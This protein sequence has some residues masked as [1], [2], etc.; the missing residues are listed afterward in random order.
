[1]LPNVTLNSSLTGVLEITGQTIYGKD[2][3]ADKIPFW[4]NSE[5]RLGYL[6]AGSGLYITGDVINAAVGS[7]SSDSIER[8]ITQS[9]HGFVVGDLIYHNGT[10]YAKSRA[11]V[12]ATAEVLGMVAAV[13]GV[14][15]FTLQMDGYITG[16]SGLTAG[17]VYY[18]STA[19]AGAMQSTAP[20]TL[21]HVDKPVFM[22][23][24]TT[25]GYIMLLRGMVV[26]VGGHDSV[27]LDASVADVFGLTGQVLSADDA[28][29]DMIPFWDD[30]AGKW[31][32]A[33]IGAGLLMTGTTLSASGDCVK[34]SSA[35]ASGS[36]SIDFTGLDTTT[37][38]S[39]QLRFANVAPATDNVVMGVRFS[40][41]GSWQS[42]ASTYQG[43]GT[44]NRM[45]SAGGTESTGAVVDS[46]GYISY[47]TYQGNSTNEQVTGVMDFIG[48]GLTCQKS[49]VWHV[50][51]RISNSFPYTVQGG[52]LFVGST[53]AVDG[54]RILMSS[55]N[56][57]T[58]EFT[59]YGYK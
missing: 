47:S 23:S 42:T 53:S 22:A 3:G 12:E 24:S 49:C 25:A 4:D 5:K 45:D 41:S 51:N 14:D 35:T 28:G 6:N 8:A 19:T 57:A 29:E 33:T 38:K 7:S 58:G 21:G 36:A 46:F 17:T 1:M 50:V 10:I 39:F 44:A 40:I 20:A 37:Y 43:G 32:Y 27:T 55:G 11:D 52:F 54:I 48:L 30:S 2:A 34:I 9:A 56:I 18:L 26:S 59:L 15:D 13:A 16:L 31:V